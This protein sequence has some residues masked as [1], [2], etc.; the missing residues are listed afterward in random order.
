MRFVWVLITLFST[1]IAPA[2]AQS[3]KHQAVFIF[4]E[5]LE[6]CG[7]FLQKAEAERKTRPP[8]ATAT[9]V[10]DKDYAALIMYT[11]GFLTG[12]N[13]WDVQNPL[14]GDAID[15]IGRMKWIENYCQTHPLEKFYQALISFRNFLK[16]QRQ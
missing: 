14:I 13:L 9:Q 10:Y 2:F 1:L 4:G 7:E 5:G 3:P 15:T 16:D 8:S 11:D 6:S 12:A